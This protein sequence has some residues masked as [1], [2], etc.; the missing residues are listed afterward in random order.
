MKKSL[1]RITEGLRGDEA[2]AKD[3]V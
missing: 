3:L 2:S 1:S